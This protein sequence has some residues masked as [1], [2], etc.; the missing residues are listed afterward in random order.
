MG[1]EPSRVRKGGT[2]GQPGECNRA[3]AGFHGGVGA[4]WHGPFLPSYRLQTFEY[5]SPLKTSV[6][7]ELSDRGRKHQKFP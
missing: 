2:G 3:G 1:K 5:P 6:V 4:G 7:Q